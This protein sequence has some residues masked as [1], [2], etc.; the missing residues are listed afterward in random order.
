MIIL[1]L[2]NTVIVSINT[3]I[4]CMFIKTPFFHQSS[5]G[6]LLAWSQLYF[7]RKSSDGAC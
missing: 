3:I 5:L 6:F 4:V 7:Y 2:K 1:I